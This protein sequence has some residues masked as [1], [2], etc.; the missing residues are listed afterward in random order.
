LARRPRDVAHLRQA[1]HTLGQDAF[2]GPAART[3]E[4][5]RRRL[6]ERDVAH[7]AG[8]LGVVRHHRLEQG[9]ERRLRRRIAEHEVERV[10]PDGRGDGVVPVPNDPEADDLE[11]VRSRHQV[12]RDPERKLVARLVAF[13]QRAGEAQEL[14]GVAGAQDLHRPMLAGGQSDHRPASSASTPFAL[15]SG[16]GALGRPSLAST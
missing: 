12:P 1:V 11:G 13:E 10:G 4:S 5:L 14:H 7:D 3:G 15:A 8:H 2:G 9:T 16:D 6:D